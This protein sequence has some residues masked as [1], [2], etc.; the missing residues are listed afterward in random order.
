MIPARR[1]IAASIT[2][3]SHLRASPTVRSIWRPLIHTTRSRSHSSTTTT[4]TTTTTT[5]MA[6]HATSEAEADVERAYASALARLAQLQSNRAI[7]SLF[8]SSSPAPAAAKDTDLN[9]LAIPEMLAW[10]RRA[11]YTPASLAA[12]GLRCVHVAG[13]KG[14]GSTAACIASILAQ[15]S[16]DQYHATATAAADADAQGWRGEAAGGG[17][18]GGAPAAA[19]GLYTSPHVFSVRERIALDGKPIS[20]AKFARYV[21]EVWERLTQAAREEA[22]AAK[23]RIVVSEEELRGP[24]T[25]PFYFRF[26]TILALHV[27]VREGVRWAVVECGI[28]GEYDATNVLPAEAVTAAVVTHLELDHVNMLGDTVEKIAWHKSGIFKPG[29]KAFW[30]RTE[31][32]EHVGTRAV[33]RERAAEKG[34]TLV[35]VG[36]TE[37]EAWDSPKGERLQGEFQIFNQAL[38]VYAAREHLLRTGVKLDGVFGT[39]EWTLNDCPREFVTGLR[40]AALPG[41]SEVVKDDDDVEWHLDGAHTEDSLR[42]VGKWFAGRSSD[43]R[44]GP[45][46]SVRVLV[47]NQQER[48]PSGLLNALLAGA[49][50]RGRGSAFTHAIFTRNEEKD[51]TEGED[52]DLS[53]QIKAEKALRQAVGGAT[54][55]TQTTVHTSVPSATARVRDIAAQARKDGKP[56]KVLVTGSFHLVGPVLKTLGSF[57]N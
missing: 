1:S 51:P 37:L 44:L 7:T 8:D 17:G 11:G 50:M 31:E 13:T 52:R 2:Q 35:E 54:P 38:A 36:R 18:G 22:A 21:D 27:F 41:R 4:T 23:G 26:L 57:E 20:K 48:D 55:G 5:N 24:G 49:D 33:L 40:E 15:Y 10:L 34:A 3:A 45:D 6:T 29:V 14:K 12:S 46:N 32:D 53:A 39:D 30:I 9:A 28:G 56:C 42:Y 16:K 47:F 19:V 43:D 25:K